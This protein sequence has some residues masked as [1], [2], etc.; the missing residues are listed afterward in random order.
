[1]YE[2]TTVNDVGFDLPLGQLA[3]GIRR[4]SL[5]QATKY[6]PD[7]RSDEDEL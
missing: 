7:T 5:Q 6:S 1:M 4:C 3:N 2:L